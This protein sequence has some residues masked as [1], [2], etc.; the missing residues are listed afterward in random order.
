MCKSASYLLFQ[1]KKQNIEFEKKDSIQMLKKELKKWK[2]AH[3][4]QPL[5]DDMSTHYAQVLHFFCFPNESPV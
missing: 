3:F 1:H 4:G 5:E 2:E